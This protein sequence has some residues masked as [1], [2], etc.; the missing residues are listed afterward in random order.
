MIKQNSMSKSLLFL[1]S[2]CL[3]FISSH[4]CIQ[5]DKSSLPFCGSLI[6]YSNT[7]PLLGNVTWSSI[8]HLSQL[9]Y[10]Q[11]LGVLPT[12]RQQN[13]ACQTAAKRL[14]CL[15]NTPRCSLDENIP[16]LPLCDSVCKEMSSK[17]G[18]TYD[19]CAKRGVLCSDAQMARRI[20][21]VVFI[22]WMILFV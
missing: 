6:P 14:V 21:F 4:S 18:A 9:E 3:L 20:S 13:T 10:D 7:S 8:D 2:L 19:S 1:L 12:S 11:I 22:M 5:I 15:G 16:N 17:C